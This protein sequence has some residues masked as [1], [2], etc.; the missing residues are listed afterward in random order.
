[1][2]RS[3][4]TRAISAVL[5]LLFTACGDPQTPA[6]AGGD[7][8]TKA[9]ETQSVDDLRALPYLD[10]SPKR[11]GRDERDGVVAL[12]SARA[13][14]GYSLYT[15]RPFCRAELVDLRGRVVNSWR[16]TPC[17]R[18]AQAELLPDGTLLVVG[19]EA[20]SG[21]VLLRFAWNGDLL[22]RQRLPVHHD[23]EQTP[24]GQ[25]LALALTT[26]QVELAGAKRRIRD[27]VLL[28]LDD[29][30]EVVDRRSMFDLF[31]GGPA[32]NPLEWVRVREQGASD[33][34]HANSV[35]W[36]ARPELFGSSPL[37]GADHVLMSIRPQDLVAI[38]D[39]TRQGL[40]WSWGKGELAGPHDATLLDDGNVLVFDN[41]LGRNWSRVVEVDPRTDRIVWQYVADP[42][43]AFYTAALGG[44]QRLPNGNTLIAD[45]HAGEAFEVTREGEIV[46]RYLTPHKN[47]QG[48]RAAIVRMKRYDA[49][50]VEP[51]V[52]AAGGARR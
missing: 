18:W 24:S 1:M 7:A 49:S 30:G 34:F 29:R 2:W 20:K 50:L 41:G 12:D 22:W 27:D 51:L 31:A 19:R 4:R 43:E 14:P 8:A 17:G 42:P 28:L 16:S 25:I 26:R 35:E 48:Q 32:R 13:W 39:W 3:R 11:E 47:D 38:V 37:Y 33:I 40:V 36:M 9:G 21:R 44:S 46:W 15:V 45:S 6:P 23:A 5:I 52:A 10:F